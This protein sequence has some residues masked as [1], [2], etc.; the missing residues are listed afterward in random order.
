MIQVQSLDK[1]FDQN[2]VLENINFEI[3][4]GQFYTILGENGSGKS[5][6]LKLIAGMDYPTENPDGTFGNI[7]INNQ[8]VIGGSTLSSFPV[9]TWR[10]ILILKFLW[11]SNPSQIIL[12]AFTR[13]GIKSIST[14]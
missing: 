6:L 1:K 7:K 4:S 9:L 11:T 13:N 3:E 12:K 2:H 5:T 8:N 14:N 10:K